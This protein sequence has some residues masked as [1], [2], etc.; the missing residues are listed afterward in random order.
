MVS[1]RSSILSF[2]ILLLS[3]CMG[4]QAF[5]QGAV[6][7]ARYVLGSND[8][9]QIQVF[10]EEDLSLTTD[11][12]TNGTIDYPLIGDVKLSG[13][14][15]A[16]AEKLL[17]KKLRG[18]YL[19]NPQITVSIVE[20]RPFFVAGEV[21]SPGS[22][23]YQPGMTARQA[24]VIAGG[25][26]DRAKRSKVYLIREGDKTFTEQKVKLNEKIGPGD[27]ITVKEGFF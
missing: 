10:Q 11:I 8:K 24:V 4:M 9:I 7:N 19:I 17:D 20:Y 18:D 15:V 13:L 3:A 1:N 6:A 21:N 25:F 14:T 16:Q 26:T 2:I 27:T 12:S 23:E 5:A 22:Y